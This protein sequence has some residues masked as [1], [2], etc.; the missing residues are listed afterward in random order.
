MSRCATPYFAEYLLSTTT[1]LPNSLD[2]KKYPG[3]LS[4]YFIRQK[5]GGIRIATYWS[6]RDHFLRD[7]EGFRNELGAAAI[8]M[9]GFIAGF[10][11]Q[12]EPFSKRVPWYT[13]VLG[14]AAFLGAIQG[15][16]NYYDWIFRAPN[17]ALKSQTSRYQW[18]EGAEFKEVA[19]LI[20]NL[21]VAQ[22]EIVLSAFTDIEHCPA[23]AAA[24]RARSNA[25]HAGGWIARN[26]Y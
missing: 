14:V 12:P 18:I 6:T 7:G 10:T 11:I 8:K 15:I 1:I 4:Y 3:L 5:H 16:A 21:P 13:L 26:N 22:R 17:I 2:I 20:S 19:S 24:G 9:D 25:A 23:D